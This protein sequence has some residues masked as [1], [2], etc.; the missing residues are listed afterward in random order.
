[1]TFLGEEVIVLMF[2]VDSSLD[3]L[4]HDS[5]DHHA[6]PAYVTIGGMYNL[7]YFRFKR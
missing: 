6:S 3:Q 1:M 7:F 4:V 2:W 5:W